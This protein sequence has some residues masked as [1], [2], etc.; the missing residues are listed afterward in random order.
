[1]SSSYWRKTKDWSGEV[2]GSERFAARIRRIKDKDYEKYVKLFVDGTK[3]ELIP[4]DIYKMDHLEVR[5]EMQECFFFLL[6]LFLQVLWATGNKLTTL[7]D[8]LTWLTKLQNL[9]S[10][11][12]LACFLYFPKKKKK[13]KAFGSKPLRDSSQ[14]HWALSYADAFGLDQ[15]SSQVAA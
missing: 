4:P 15:E 13:K 1:M 6:L 2:L 9:V 8:E 5:A 3:L 14:V 12:W 10:R 7:P 11:D